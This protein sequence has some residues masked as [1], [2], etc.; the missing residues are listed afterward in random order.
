MALAENIGVKTISAPNS[1]QIE[2]NGRVVISA[3]GASTT[4]GFLIV[5]QAKAK[6]ISS[7]FSGR[8]LCP[9]PQNLAQES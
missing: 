6:V 9:L 5:D 4:A 1:L 7:L 2:R 8:L 3:I